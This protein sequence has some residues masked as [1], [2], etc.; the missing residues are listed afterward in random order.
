MKRFLVATLLASLVLTG[1]GLGATQHSI[2]LTGAGPQP[3]ALKIGW[4]DAVVFTNTD[5]VA[6]TLLIPRLEVTTTLEPGSTFS[7]TF[8][9]R[10]GTYPFRLQIGNRASPGTITLE[11]AGQV[12]LAASPMVVAYGNRVRVTGTSPYGD[13]AVKLEVRSAGQGVWAPLAELKADGTGA[14]AGS[15]PLTRGGAIRATVAADQL[16]SSHVTVGVRPL[17]SIRATPRRTAAGRFV[18]VAAQLR[19]AGAADSATLERFDTRRK[20]WT[21]IRTAR[22]GR[23]GNASFSLRATKGDTRLRVVVSRSAV[24]PGYVPVAT[25][26]IR[27]VGA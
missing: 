26:A 17:L 7:Q 5:T 2:S 11:V 16:R 21:R 15:L 3:A 12:R 8:E 13:S 10:E 18:K 19:P 4:G 20:S 6:R 23:S 27:I 14:F 22:V 25:K 1:L 24:K 9:G